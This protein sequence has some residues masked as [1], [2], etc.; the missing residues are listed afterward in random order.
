MPVRASVPRLSSR[1][2]R[3]AVITLATAATYG[4]LSL[5][6]DGTLQI[7]GDIVLQPSSGLAVPAGIV[8]GL[9]GAVG[10]G[11]AVLVVDAST[12]GPAVVWVAVA[13]VALALLGYELW[14]RGILPTDPPAAFEGADFWLGVLSVTA[15]SS[16]VA[17]ALLAWGYEVLGLFPF[18]VSFP[19]AV[20]DF[21]LGTL[22]VGLPA[23]S[24]VTRL[25]GRRSVGGEAA[26]AER[27]R[28]WLLLSTALLWSV[29]A[30]VGSLGFAI[31]EKLSADVFVSRGLGVL[32][33]VVHPDVFG[34]GGRRAQVVFGGLVL[35]LLAGQLLVRRGGDGWWN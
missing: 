19:S 20:V 16:V 33:E 30:L 28:F 12:L 7:G 21:A 31:R 4:V 13:H 6:F 22:L 14:N 35:T 9:P 3:D 17:A 5:L 1:Y 8:F 2:R 10:I 34:H 15:L 18:H 24:A 26:S 23:L 32:Y 25:G 11:L 27:R 29:G